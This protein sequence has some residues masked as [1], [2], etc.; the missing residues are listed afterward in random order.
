MT[1]LEALRLARTEDS[2][3][4]ALDKPTPDDEP[5]KEMCLGGIRSKLQKALFGAPCYARNFTAALP[6]E[7]PEEKHVWPG[8]MGTVWSLGFRR[9][10]ENLL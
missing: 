4:R 10:T 3:K 5:Q 6:E 8:K 2:D 1:L 9:H 7:Q